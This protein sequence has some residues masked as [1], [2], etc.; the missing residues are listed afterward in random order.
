ME[1]SR[2]S[3][4]ERT[5]GIPSSWTQSGS[6]S[7][8]STT[9][10]E[11]GQS[12]RL[13]REGMYSGAGAVAAIRCGLFPRPSKPF[14]PGRSELE[15]SCQAGQ[16]PPRGVSSRAKGLGVKLGLWSARGRCN[17]AV[18]NDSR[19]FEATQGDHDAEGKISRSCDLT[20]TTARAYLDS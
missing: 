7:A 13:R 8:R 17:I 4:G 18:L 2:R 11:R 9:S 14:F 20:R 15:T 19:A 10:Y 12:S 5:V 3:E 16:D 1:G 6:S